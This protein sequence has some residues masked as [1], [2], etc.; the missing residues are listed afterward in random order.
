FNQY[1]GINPWKRENQVITSMDFAKQKEIISTLDLVDWD[2]VIVD[3]AY[4]MA[5]YSYFY[6]N[7]IFQKTE[8]YKLGEV[9]SKNTYHLLFITATPHKGDPENFRLLLDLLN[10]GL[11]SL[12]DT[13]IQ[14]IQ[15]KENT[16]FLRRVKEDMV[17]FD[18]KPRVI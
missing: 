14:S 5:A 16:I 9:I 7:I 18:G 1:S 13:L 3:E 11:F 6:N 12:P 17:D 15:N 10:P 4:K 8:R 2:L